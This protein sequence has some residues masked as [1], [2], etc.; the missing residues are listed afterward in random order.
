MKPRVSIIVPIYNMERYIRRCLDSLISQSLQEVEI[1]AVDDGSTDDSLSIVREYVRRDA[2]IVVIPKGNGGVSSARN[3]GLKA[4]SGDY[5]GFVDPD[6]W[7]DAKMY[8]S[9]LETAVREQADIVMCSYIREFG[10]HAKPKI[11]E[12]PQILIY[13]GPELQTKLLRRLVG[14]MH[15]E[16]GRPEL[17]DA[18]GTVWSKLYR[19]ELIR[20]HDLK[21]VDLQQIGS[22]EDTLFNLYAVSCAQSFAFVNQPY[23]HYWRANGDSITSRYN[24]ALPQQ[25]RALYGLIEDFLDEQELDAEFRTALN[26]RICMNLL[27]LGLNT[28]SPANQ[29]SS[30]QK[31]K[32]IH[33]LLSEPSIRRSFRHF[34]LGPCPVVWRTFFLCAKTRFALG[35]YMLLLAIEWLRK[36]N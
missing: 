20:D 27:G 28:I 12:A 35:F 2:R 7:V 25:F 36:R 8:Q 13:R 33:T 18:W 21:F 22:N 26:N 34:D 24:P 6:D 11:Y 19:A 5:I 30:Y 15:K 17:L 10:D 4:A 3:Q 23:Y 32:A 1:I 31:L 14:P 29:A 16:V 9:L